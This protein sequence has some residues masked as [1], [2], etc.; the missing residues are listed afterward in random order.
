ML[1]A[2]AA[3]STAARTTESM[4]KTLRKGISFGHWFQLD[5]TG[6]PRRDCQKNVIGRGPPVAERMIRLFPSLPQFDKRGPLAAFILG[7]FRNCG[8]VGMALEE[9]AN[10]APENAGAMAV[11]YADPRKAG[12]KCPIQI[13]L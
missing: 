12:E 9:I 11:N 1:C 10:P 7:G 3:A 13:L 8:H 5:H 4:R 2:W 6:R